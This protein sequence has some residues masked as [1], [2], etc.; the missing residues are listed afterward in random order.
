[1]DS[2]NIPLVLLSSVGR[3]TLPHLTQLRWIARSPAGLEAAKYFAT[4]SLVDLEVSITPPVLSNSLSPSAFR[5][6]CTSIRNT[7]LSFTTY[8]PFLLRFALHFTDEIPGP[9]SSELL[10]V[11]ALFPKLRAITSPFQTLAHPSLIRKLSSMA[12]LRSVKMSH[13]EDEYDQE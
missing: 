1:M 3:P 6:F 11:L 12:C 9:L 5:S 4:C 10:D 13:Y 8:A 2:A 7:L